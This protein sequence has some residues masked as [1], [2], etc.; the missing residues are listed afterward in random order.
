MGRPWYRGAS[1]GDPGR[2]LMKHRM[3]SLISAAESHQSLTLTTKMGWHDLQGCGRY[4]SGTH[5]PALR[6]IRIV[7]TSLSMII[8]PSAARGESKRCCLIRAYHRTPS[9]NSIGMWTF[10]PPRN[11]AFG[12]GKS[13]RLTS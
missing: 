1:H 3:R 10:I 12:E 13:A 9:L 8:R 5:T 7:S 4:T 11:M 6:S 2:W